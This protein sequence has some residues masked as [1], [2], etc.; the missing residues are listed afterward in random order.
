M[1]LKF[2]ISLSLFTILFAESILSDLLYSNCINI[3]TSALTCTNNAQIFKSFVIS[4]SYWFLSP[5][6]FG[7]SISDT[8]G[9]CAGVGFTGMIA[10][11]YFAKR[12]FTDTL[13]FGSFVYLAVFVLFVIFLPFCVEYS[14]RITNYIRFLSYDDGLIIALASLILGMIGK[15]FDFSKVRFWTKKSSLSRQS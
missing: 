4:G 2:T 11:F 13:L 15:M 5:F 9:I 12:I 14:C 8:M 6:Q 3:G 7:R 1:R 10:S